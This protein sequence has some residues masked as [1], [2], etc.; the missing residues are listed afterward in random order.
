[1]RCVHGLCEQSHKLVLLIPQGHSSSKNGFRYP[2]SLGSLP[3]PHGDMQ[4]H[5]LKLFKF[6]LIH[7][8]SPL[9]AAQPVGERG[10]MSFTVKGSI[11]Q[12]FHVGAQPKGTGLGLQIPALSLT[13]PVTRSPSQDW[14][15]SYLPCMVFVQINHGMCKKHTVGAYEW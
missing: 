3:H 5:Y 4:R 1:M 14:S 12:A 15:R 6:P 11:P 9:D 13:N 2:V 7:H 8:I 10:R